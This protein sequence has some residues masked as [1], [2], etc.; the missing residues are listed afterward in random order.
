[1]THGRQTR[2]FIFIDDII[3][4]ILKLATA[5]EAVGQAFNICSGTETPIKDFA[6]AFNR[7]LKNPI[8]I[9]FSGIPTPENEASRNLGDYSKLKKVTGWEPTTT[10]KQGIQEIIEHRNL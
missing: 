6:L 9:Q 2:D 5:K 8:D 1:M 7:C 4:A 3:E 10:L